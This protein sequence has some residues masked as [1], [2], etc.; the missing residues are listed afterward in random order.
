[1]I[2]VL[3][4]VNNERLEMLSTVKLLLRVINW[5]N[6]ERQKRQHRDKTHMWGKSAESLLAVL[7]QNK[8][9]F[10]WWQRDVCK[11]CVWNLP[12]A[13]FLGKVMVRFVA[14]AF[15]LA[16]CIK[17]SSCVSTLHP[18]AVKFADNLCE[19]GRNV[20]IQWRVQSNKW[21]GDPLTSCSP[22]AMMFVIF[23]LIL[24][25]RAHTL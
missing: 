10:H 17:R 15:R 7:R 3:K 11:N 14:I 5:S 25:E 6:N 20:K 21:Y 4:E 18:M 12:E 23:T 1:M 9:H 8:K 19:M 24:T 13:V 22:H 2:N 16:S